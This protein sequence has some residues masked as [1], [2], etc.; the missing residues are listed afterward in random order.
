MSSGSIFQI[1]GNLHNEGILHIVSTNPGM[2]NASL[3]ALNIFNGVNGT[4]T[5]ALP[6]GG[7]A[8][9]ANAIGNL[10]LTLTAINTFVNQ[11]QIIGGGNVSVVADNVTNS[12][13]IQAA[14]NLSVLSSSIVNSG[15]LAALTGSVNLANPAQYAATVQS[16]S[17]TSLSALLNS[18]MGSV[19]NITNTGV[20]EA[21]AGSVNLGGRWWRAVCDSRRN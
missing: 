11:G 9:Y 16:L 4:I 17:N 15:T 21:L 13:V 2:S 14:N 18:S 7:L 12:G 5:T 3:V 19:V 20:I 6:I 8:G 1:D 10:S